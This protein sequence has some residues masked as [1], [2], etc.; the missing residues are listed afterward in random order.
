MA[1][2]SNASS[3]KP[4]IINSL[5]GLLTWVGSIIV[6]IY[7]YNSLSFFIYNQL[8]KIKIFNDYAQITD[9]LSFIISIPL[10]FLISLFLFK[11]IRKIISS[12]L[13]KQILG[14]I[15]DK[16]FGLLYGILF[17]YI[18]FSTLLYGINHFDYF[19]NFTQWI[20]NNSYILQSINEINS[21]VFAYLILYEEV[22]TN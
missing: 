18:I 6:T 3:V 16:I 19:Q 4:D 11:K 22:P 10:V 20:I 13:D 21:N 17:S 5:L 15:F 9:L 14:I 2:K 1:L 8:I 7:S 12:D